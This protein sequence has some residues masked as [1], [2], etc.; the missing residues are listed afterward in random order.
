ML[1]VAGDAPGE[2]RQIIRL[3]RGQTLTGRVADA[4]TGR[5]VA[6]VGVGYAPTVEGD[7]VP[8]IF[9]LGA[10]TD[11]DGRYRLVVPSGRGTLA[12]PGIPP[13]FS[14]ERA[15]GAALT[16][17]VIVMV[18]NLIARLVSYYFSPKGE[19]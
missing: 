15:W 8:T 14:L 4:A 19:R 5:G 7:Q 2:F 9:G 10:K 17:L 3:P 12:F 1:S 6:G 18:L 13:E 16:L 11:A